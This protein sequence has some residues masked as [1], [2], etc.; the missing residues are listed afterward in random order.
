[1][2][3]FGYGNI[4]GIDYEYAYER[5]RIIAVNLIKSKTGRLTMKL[6]NTFIFQGILNHRKQKSS[7]VDCEEIDLISAKYAEAEDDGTLDDDDDELDFD[8]A[9]VDLPD[10]QF[11]DRYISDLA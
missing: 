6:W 3:T 5:Y 8:Q 11:L 1:V 7:A 2:F 10:V 9:L 4:S